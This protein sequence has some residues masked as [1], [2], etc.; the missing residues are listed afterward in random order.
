MSD[1]LSCYYN[2]HLNGKPL[3]EDRRNCIE[4][5]SIEELDNG[6]NTCSII[7]NDPEF[8]YIED[9]IFIEEATVFAEFGWWGETYRDTFSG[10]VS[11]IDISFPD[12]GYPQ[13]TIFCLDDTHIMNRK[14]KTRSWDKVTRA[15]VVKKIAAEYGFKCVIQ[16]GYSSTVEDSISQSGVTDI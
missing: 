8:K 9:N 14:K 6:S 5:V 3:S 10:Y 12:N 16:S 7:M 2:V 11:A 1:V 13:L 4:S 15:D